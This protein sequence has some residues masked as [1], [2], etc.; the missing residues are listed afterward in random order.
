MQFLRKYCRKHEIVDKG[1]EF[2]SVVFIQHPSWNA[3]NG[4]QHS[5]DAAI[6][7]QQLSPVFIIVLGRGV[8]S[9]F[10]WGQIFLFIFQCHLTIEKLE[11]KH[12]ICSNLTLFIVP[13]FFSLF[14]LFFLFFLFSFFFFFFLGGRRRPPAPQMTPSGSRASDDRCDGPCV[15]SFL[16]DSDKLMW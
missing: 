6:H 11:N 8:I 9:T 5:T 7:S 16:T 15:A 1:K 10:S 12:F 3:E 2:H 4:L 13:F 14:F